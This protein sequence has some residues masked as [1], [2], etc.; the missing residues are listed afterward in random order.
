[1]ATARV[2]AREG[3]EPSLAA[4]E[5]RQDSASVARCAR[6]KEWSQLHKLLQEGVAPGLVDDL[7]RTALHYAAGYGE[8]GTVD[9]LVKAGADVNACDRAGMTPLHWACLKGHAA[10]VDVLLSDGQVD[11]FACATGGIFRGRCALDLAARDGAV[12]EVPPQ[13]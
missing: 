13:S 9:A 6:D 1:M 7:G 2:L 8:L 5:A 10:A 4:A 11:A 12:R 3:T